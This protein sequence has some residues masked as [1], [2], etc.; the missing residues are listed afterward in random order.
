MTDEQLQRLAALAEAATPARGIAEQGMGVRL[1]DYTPICMS[2]V[3]GEPVNVDARFIAAARDAVPELLAEVSGLRRQLA[4]CQVWLERISLAAGA[5]D[6]TP[7]AILT[8]LT[9]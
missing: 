3:T 9:E 5:D 2:S 6:A 8:A 1:A 7:A 4:E